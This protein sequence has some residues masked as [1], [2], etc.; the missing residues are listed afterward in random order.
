MLP[1]TLRGRYSEYS[2]FTDE[3][4]VLA[5]RYTPGEWWRAPRQCLSALQVL[6]V[7]SST[8][9]LLTTGRKMCKCP[10]IVLVKGW[11]CGPWVPGTVSL[12]IAIFTT[13]SPSCQDLAV[14]VYQSVRNCVLTHIMCEMLW[15]E[16][17]T[18]RCSSCLWDWRRG[19]VQHKQKTV[20]DKYLMS[21]GHYLQNPNFP[22]TLMLGSLLPSN[23]PSESFPVTQ[24]R[25]Y[26]SHFF[27]T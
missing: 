27:L 11:Y 9:W 8:D 6:H 7:A 12:G 23:S 22:D 10:C 14:W 24:G 4:Q 13:P 25:H 15:K 3:V 16:R 17:V 26:Y 20:E 5:Q 19:E 18:H 2:H 1:V 21:C